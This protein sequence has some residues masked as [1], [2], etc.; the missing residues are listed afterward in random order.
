VSFI[1]L[2]SLTLVVVLAISGKGEIS[3]PAVASLALFVAP[4]YIDVAAFT[5]YQPVLFG[6]AAITV[7]IL[8]TTGPLRPAE[9]T[10]AVRAQRRA[11]IS[12]AR[13]RDRAIA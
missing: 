4:S 3:T 6:V 5:D 11:A 1:A 13:V 8:S 7:S 10:F 9:S 2:L 12:R